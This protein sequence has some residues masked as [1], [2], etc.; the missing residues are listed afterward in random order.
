M[1]CSL[2]NT[3]QIQMKVMPVSDDLFDE[4]W[5]LLTSHKNKFITFRT[6]GATV[7]FDSRVPTQ[8]EIN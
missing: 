5:K 1:Y 6:N 8:R 7:N 3:N 4:N 2:I